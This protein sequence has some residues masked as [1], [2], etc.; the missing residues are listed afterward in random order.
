[1][2]DCR[3]NIR[4]RFGGANCD[5]VFPNLMDRSEMLIRF[6]AAGCLTSHSILETADKIAI[7]L[8]QKRSVRKSI[9]ASI[10]VSNKQGIG[11]RLP[12][13]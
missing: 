8:L 7:D 11:D 1:M 12:C 9:D 4:L 13:K 2:K 6:G 10:S 3:R 5:N